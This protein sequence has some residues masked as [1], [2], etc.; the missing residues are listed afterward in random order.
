M[1]AAVILTTGNSP[2]K[3]QTA[4]STAVLAV[5][6]ALGVVL[7]LLAMRQRRRMGRPRKPPAWMASMDRLSLWSAAGLA[8][9]LQ[10]W[11]LVAAGATTVAGAKLATVGSYLALV[12]F[13]LLAT[14][15]MA[16][17]S[18]GSGHHRRVPAARTLAD[19]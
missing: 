3:P 11:A 18:P 4:P 17:L 13:C 8:A 19:R 2:P 10:P 12:F 9:F 16:G 14:A 6:L 7:I 1:I 15:G 5:K